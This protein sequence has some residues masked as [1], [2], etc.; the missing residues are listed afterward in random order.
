MYQSVGRAC[1]GG[2]GASSKRM[3]RS[4]EAQYETCASCG[5][6]LLPAERAFAFERAVSE[7]AVLCYSCAIERGGAYDEVY[8]RWTKSPDVADLLG[9][10]IDEA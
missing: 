1:E 3:H 7:D 5:T 10:V 4:E 2:P 8:D 6:E 9:D